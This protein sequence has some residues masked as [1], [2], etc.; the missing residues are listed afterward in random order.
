MFVN[1]DDLLKHIDEYTLYCHYLEFEPDVNLSYSS[2]LRAGDERFSFGI[3]ASRKSRSSE[4]MWKDNGLGISGDI[5]SLVKHIYGY[6]NKT[7][8]AARIKSDFGLGFAVAP[9]EKIIRNANASIPKEVDIRVVPKEF[10]MEDL[11]W[12]KQFNISQELLTRYRTSPLYAYWMTKNQ[13]AP[14]FPRGLSYVYRIHDRYQLYFASRWKGMKFR[15]DLTAQNHV[16]GFQQL[17][18]NTDT[19]IITKSYKDVMTLRSFGYEAVAPTGESTPMPPTFFDWADMHYR[20][21]VVLFDNDMKHRGD[22]YPYPKV[23]V[24]VETGA[25]DISDFT[26]DYSP[27]A[28]AELLRTILYEDSYML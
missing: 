17:Q 16:L 23:Y 5:F 6:Q 19:L 1:D 21:K 24:P 13:E 14:L 10:S 3:F 18:Y 26:R 11:N 7:E 2:P 12:W 22:L 8:A 4:Y 28:A 9:K 15:S 25:K 20:K 27:S